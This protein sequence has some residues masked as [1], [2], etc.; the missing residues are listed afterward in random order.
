MNI[1][2]VHNTIPLHVALARGAKSCVGLLLSAGANC[3]L[4]VFLQTYEIL[5]ED[6]G[7]LT[8]NNSSVNLSLKNKWYLL[9]QHARLICYIVLLA[10][11]KLM[12][13]HPAVILLYL[14]FLV[15]QN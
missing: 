2:N 1:Q 10:S 14:R 11:I 5:F 13:L 12:L 4:Q 8:Q 7:Y 3:N 6:Y 15:I 9:V